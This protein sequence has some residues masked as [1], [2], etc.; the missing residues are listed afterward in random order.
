[1]DFKLFAAVA[2]IFHLLGL[3]SAVKA[4]MES[5]TPQGATAWALGLITFP[6]VAVPALG[7]RAQQISRFCQDASCR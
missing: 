3:L 5:R 4:I 1:M 7:I 2:S 6:Y